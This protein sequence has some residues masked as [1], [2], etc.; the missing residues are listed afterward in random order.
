MKPD[1]IRKSDVE[2]CAICLGD[3]VGKDE[4]VQLMCHRNHVFHFKC[5]KQ[6]LENVRDQQIGK[7]KC[8]MCQAE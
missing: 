5:L 3:F 2:E 6:F 4:V 8:P 7:A 1:D